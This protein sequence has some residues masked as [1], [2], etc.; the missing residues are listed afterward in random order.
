MVRRSPSGVGDGLP[1]MPDGEPLLARWFVLSMLVL[2][3]VAVVLMVVALTQRVAPPD[4]VFPAAARRPPGTAEVTHERGEVTVAADD[5]TDRPVTC[6]PDLALVGDDGGRGTLRRA[7]GVLCQQLT[8]QPEALAVVARGLARLEAEGGIVRIAQAVATGV[9]SST[10]VEG[11]VLV[12]ELAPKFQFDDGRLGAPSLAHELAHLGG[13]VWPG[14]PVD[15]ADELV[16]LTVQAVVCDGLRREEDLPRGCADAA[17]VL[18]A[19]DPA[20][21]LREAGYPG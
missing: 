19:D 10:R 21:A 20:G 6:A 16:A 14:Q 1:A 18:G 5:T 7:F 12:V 11:G 9:D 13:E 8:E 2:S 4:E 3:I 17:G 15:V